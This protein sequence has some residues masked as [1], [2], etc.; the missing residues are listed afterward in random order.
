[1]VT[2]IVL[3]K[4]HSNKVNEIA[5]ELADMQSVSEVYSVGG[6]HDLVVLVRANTNAEVSDV[7]TKHVLKVNG[8]EN[9]K[10]MVAFRAYSKS[11]LDRVFTAGFKD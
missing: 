1:M 9:S 6:E 7:V 10:T 11:D 4:V 3:L 5:E 2:A 8:V